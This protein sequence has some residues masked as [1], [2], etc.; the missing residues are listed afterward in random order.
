[1]KYHSKRVL[2]IARVHWSRAQAMYLFLQ[3]KNFFKLKEKIKYS[4]NLEIHI[5]VCMMYTFLQYGKM[6]AKNTN[7]FMKSI[8]SI[9]KIL[10][11]NQE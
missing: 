8:K 9:I 5:I 11:N 7:F 6:S 3:Y 10:G 2:G 4:E 1:M